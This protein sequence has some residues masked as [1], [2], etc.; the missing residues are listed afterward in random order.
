MTEKDYVIKNAEKLRC[1]YTTGSCAAAAAAASAEMALTGKKSWGAR[2]RLPRGEEVLFTVNNQEISQVSA[3]CSVTKDGGDDPDV[4]SGLEIFADVKLSEDNRFC[5]EAE[6]IVDGGEGVGRVTKAGLRVPVGKAAI[7]PVPLKMIEKSVSNVLEKHGFK[8]S[9]EVIISVPKGAETALKTFNHR[10]GIE[11]GISILGTTGVVEPMSEKALV[12]TIR[13]EIDFHKAAD[14]EKI[15]IT[16]GNFGS[17]FIREYMGIDIT[18]A[19]QC[20]NYIG[21]TLD[22]IRYSGLKKI[23]LVGHTGKLIKLAA[24]IMNTHSSY[25]DGRMEVIATHAAMAGA[26]RKEVCRIMNCITTD[27]AMDVIRG[28]SFYGHVKK[29]IMEKA[30]DH[31]NFRLKNQCRIETIMFTSDRSHI[32]KSDGADKLAEEFM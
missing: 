21:E 32:M 30:L 9:A 24:G 20:S 12:D 13:T 23:L 29:S 7:N 8:G 10:L 18:K 2:I 17:D 6:I 22:Y 11:G 28:E 31:L 25:A 1:G 3:R 19:V 26:D 16:P 5:R 4:T 15:L 14:R 27:E